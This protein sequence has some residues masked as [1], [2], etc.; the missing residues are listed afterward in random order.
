MSVGEAMQMIMQMMMQV[1]KGLNPFIT[2]HIISKGVKGEQYLLEETLKCSFKR[3]K[4]ILRKEQPT[5]TCLEPV[6]GN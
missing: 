5:V 1:K 2:R 4:N 6:H 3:G